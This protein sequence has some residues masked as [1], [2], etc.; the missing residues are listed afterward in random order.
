ML[1]MCLVRYL[2]PTYYNS[3]RIG[4][5]NKTFARKFDFKEIK[6]SIKF[7]DN[8]KIVKKEN[9]I[10]ISV[11]GYENKEKYPKMSKILP[12]DIHLGLLLL[13]EEDKRQYFL[14]KDFNKFMYDNILHCGR[15]KFYF[16]CSQAFSTGEIFK[17]HVVDCFKIN[18]KQ[19]IKMHKKGE[20]VVSC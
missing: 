3:A 11:F 7:R 4:K 1:E 16:Y 19:S 10:G 6:F 12:K 17:S 15:K 5:V 2:H 9:C 14:I 20:Y 8:H 18:G 13:R